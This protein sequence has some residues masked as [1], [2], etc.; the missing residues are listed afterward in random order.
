MQ[1]RHKV[2][3][4]D[5]EESMRELLRLHLGNAGYEVTAAEDAVVAAQCLLKEKPDV[6]IVDVEMPYMSGY[7]FVAA[8]KADPATRDIPVVFLTTDPN[9]A[10]EARKLK[11]HGYLN[12]PVLAPRLLE[13]VALMTG[14]DR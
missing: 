10:E 12:K 3:V 11:A 7:E 9:V 1:R 13:V 14:S 5:D 8:V 4:V 6:M 2:L